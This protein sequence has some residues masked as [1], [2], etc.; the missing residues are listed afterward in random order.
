MVLPNLQNVFMNVYN[1][2]SMRV[3]IFPSL[4]CPCT[5]AVIE[6]GSPLQ[7]V[8]SIFCGSSMRREGDPDDQDL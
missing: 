2:K 1:L 8:F 7:C 4:A 5:A 3:H 6:T